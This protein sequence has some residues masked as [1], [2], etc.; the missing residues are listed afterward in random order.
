MNKTHAILLI[1]DISGYTQ[2]MRMHKISIN[3]AKQIVVRLL[4]SL[5]KASK[6]PLKVA[7]LE[8]D[9]VFFY[10]L[11]AEN[12]ISK[13]AEAVKGQIMELH[14]SFREELDILMDIRVCNCDACLNAGQLKLK[15][16]VH[17]GEVEVEKIHN[18][19]Q[20]FGL[21]VIVVHRMLKNSLPSREY[22]MMTDSVYSEF[23]DFYGLKP[24]SHKEN[25]EGIGEVS[26]VVFYPENIPNNSR[27][28]KPKRV[29]SLIEKI[30]WFAKL[31]VRTIV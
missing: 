5:I 29:P 22:I 10:A 25:F 4:K 20:I 30:G 7:E 28:E 21:D 11:C 16:I 14:N 6:T 2:F 8:G 3:H 17:A 12:E 15:Q 1:A 13:T 24:E 18:I 19:K 23:T 26:A 27:S 9:A 31:M